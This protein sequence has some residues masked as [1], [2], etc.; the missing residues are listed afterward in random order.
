[1]GGLQQDFLR[2]LRR[3][4][5]PRRFPCLMTGSGNRRYSIKTGPTRKDRIPLS[6]WNAQPG[7]MPPRGVASCR[8]QS[9]LN[10]PDAEAFQFNAPSSR[11]LSDITIVALEQVISMP[12][13]TR[14]LA[15]LGAR[16]IKIERPGTG[17]F[18]RHHDKRVRGKLC[19]H[20]VW[21]N[22]NKESLAL[23]I[24]EPRDM[25]V[26]RKLVCEK[27]D[28]FV[29]NLRPGDAEKM[30]LGYED[31]KAMM[32]AAYPGE[33]R[34]DRLI[35]ASISGYGANGPY[36]HKK[37]YDLLVQAEAGLVSITG[38]KDEMAKVG[39][40]IAD[41]AA[42]IYAYSSILGAIIQRQKTGRGCEIDVSMLESLVEWM[43]FPLYYAFEGQTAPKRAG[44]AHA[45]IYPYGPFSTGVAP[46]GSLGAQ[47]MLG[48]QNERE[49]KILA[50]EVLERGDLT[51]N[52]KFQDTASRSD[53]R[54]ELE[55]I[56]SGIFASWGGGAEEVVRRLEK[57]GIANAK[58][59]D[60][61]GV[62]EHEQLAARK[63]FRQVDTEVGPIQ[64]FLPPGM[65]SDL[66][67][68][69]ERIPAVG[70][71]NEKILSELGDSKAKI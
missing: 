7:P 27:A 64:A 58:V 42:G 54:A 66:D 63:R 36:A 70:E 37:A 52:P 55:A 32:N 12:L 44:A 8:C 2:L 23:D 13:A 4:S 28:V 56:I 62:W 57:A 38:T 5:T 35:Y 25:E 48:V 22:R 6:R 61:Q 33:A 39:C 67:A 49:W 69:M 51:T 40:S 30:G 47:V 65:S 59:N 45:S 16:V 41:I 9:T 34:G 29:Q 19:S 15:D 31:M 1:M 46:D 71:H 21:T 50:T 20:F 14:H 11:P 68:R 3:P 18:V 17:D 43:G 60:M 10:V 53:N 26:L 24:K